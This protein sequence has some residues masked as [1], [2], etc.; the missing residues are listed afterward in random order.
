M[1]KKIIIALLIGF[2]LL[3][4]SELKVELNNDITIKFP[5]GK[6]YF[7]NPVVDISYNQLQDAIKNSSNDSAKIYVYRWYQRSDIME[8]IFGVKILAY[9]RITKDSIK[10]YFKN[11]QGDWEIYQSAQDLVKAINNYKD[12]VNKNESDFG[13]YVDNVE[14]FSKLKKYEQYF[15]KTKGIGLTITF[16][17][18]NNT[19]EN[20]SGAGEGIAPPPSIP[21]MTDNTTETTEDTTQG[22]GT[23][24]SELATV[25]VEMPPLT[26]DM[27]NTVGEEVPNEVPPTTEMNNTADADD[28]VP[29]EGE[30]QAQET[31]T[32]ELP[33]MPGLN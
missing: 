8:G 17:L 29:V 28:D 18:P 6:T 11:P 15:I 21:D 23:T 16:S 20:I 7:F 4:A 22:Q 33:P 12:Y 1:Y 3:K 13:K 32:I 9:V 26:P 30:G 24:E 14:A 10:Y 19:A 2:S 31:E 27:N 5:D 25:E